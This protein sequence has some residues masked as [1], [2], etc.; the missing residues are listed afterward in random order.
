MSDRFV[1]SMNFISKG[2]KSGC[3]KNSVCIRAQDDCF[4]GANKKQS[5]CALNTKI[6]I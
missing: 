4:V 3:G 6:T 1:V 5:F 2:L